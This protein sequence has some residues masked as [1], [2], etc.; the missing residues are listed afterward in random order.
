MVSG[1]QFKWGFLPLEVR[2]V[3]LRDSHPGNI[4]SREQDTP[5]PNW[6][7]FQF[8]FLSFFKDKGQAVLE[9]L[10]R[11]FQRVPSTLMFL[12]FNR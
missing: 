9:G 6:H 7:L 5:G 8:L 2:I 12:P 10:L 4:R 1:I 11:S 3:F